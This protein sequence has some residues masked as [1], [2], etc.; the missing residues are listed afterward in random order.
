[1]DKDI[2]DRLT[3]IHTSEI[4]ARNGYEE[5]LV[6]AEGKGLSPLFLDMVALHDGNAKE[7]A[8]VLIGHGQ[9]ADTEGSFMS[10]VNRTIMNVRSLFDALGDGVLSG[11]IDGEKRNLAKY[12]E[13]LETALP[14]PVVD[15]LTAQ[16]GK[17]AQ[18]VAIMEMQRAA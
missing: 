13:A 9:V 6:D 1:M 12:D 15:L 7:I 17:I 2:L 4:D 10:V 3:S 11:L 8:E 14:A 5:A 18:K 16:R